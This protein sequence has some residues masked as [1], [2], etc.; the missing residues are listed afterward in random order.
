MNAGQQLPALAPTDAQTASPLQKH[1]IYWFED[2]SLVLH[3]KDVLFRVHR[4]LL[5]R[6]S[7]YLASLTNTGPTL[8]LPPIIRETGDS[9]SYALLGADRQINSRD[10]EALL[11]HMYHDL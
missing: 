1:P 7:P 4:S 9:V 3:V 8:N 5:E 2:G 6:H 10:V 11:E